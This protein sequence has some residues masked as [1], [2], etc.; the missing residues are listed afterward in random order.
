MHENILAVDSIE[1]IRFYSNLVSIW[2][3]STIHVSFFENKKCYDSFILLIMMHSSLIK[4]F[5]VCKGN[6]LAQGVE[7]FFR[8]WSCGISNLRGYR[9]EQNASKI[10]P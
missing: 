6:T 4:A 3:G 2:N 8:T 9:A 7:T 10:S 1:V 5:C